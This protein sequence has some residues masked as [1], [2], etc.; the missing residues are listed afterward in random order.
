[1]GCNMDKQKMSKV[2]VLAGV[3]ALGFGFV[4]TPAWS[5]AVYRCVNSEGHVTISNISSS[6]DCRRIE[7]APDNTVPAPAQRPATAGNRTPGAAANTT[8]V[9]FP[10]VS[11]DAQK[12]R[13]NDRRTILEQELV[14]E[15][16][17]LEQARKDLAEQEAVRFGDE[18]NF[19]RVKDRLLPFQERVAQHE[20]NVQALEKE[21]AN[22]R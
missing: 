13:D 1:M 18:R 6:K 14:N 21:I 19:Q 15:K 4:A 9:D 2:S 3:L 20:R 7:L 11:G 12:A 10:K 16:K 5:Q 17:S 8:P 22:L